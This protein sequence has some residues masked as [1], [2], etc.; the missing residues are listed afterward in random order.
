MALFL[1]NEQV[2]GKLDDHN[3][4]LYDELMQSCLETGAYCMIDLHNFARYDGGIIGQGGPPDEVFADIWSQ[5]AHKYAKEDRVMFGLMNEPHDLDVGLW[6][7]SCQA[8]VTSIRKAGATL[9]LILLPGT[10]FTNAE[11]FVTTGSADVLA[12]ITNPDGSSD[13]LIL[14]LHKYLDINNS[15]SFEECTTDNIEAFQAMA[16]W[17]RENKRVAIISESGASMSDSCMERFCAQN[18]FIAKNSDVFIGFVG[19]GAGSFKYDYIMTLTPFQNGDRFEDNKLMKECIIG[20][21]IKNAPASTIIES[22]T[23]TKSC[24]TQTLTRYTRPTKSTA[25]DGDLSTIESWRSYYTTDGAAPTSQPILKE[26]S[27]SA[28]SRDTKPDDNSGASRSLGSFIGVLV[29]LVGFVI[30]QAF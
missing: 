19:W 23:K 7:K 14:D 8:A 10:N 22:K 18:Q 30:F 28:E 9:Q 26:G 27:K 12:D 17:L 16:N 29:S 3:F 4:G 20:P 13:G 21:F 25:S 5:L 11:T 6:A 15:G 1:L 2:G 24:Q